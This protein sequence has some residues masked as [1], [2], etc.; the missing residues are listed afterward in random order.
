[1]FY[2][3]CIIVIFKSVGHF[4][5]R[6]KKLFSFAKAEYLLWG[7]KKL[8]SFAKAEYLLWGPKKLFSFAKAEYLLW[9]PKKISG[10][11]RLSQ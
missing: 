9:G 4:R 10:M 5:V 11:K 7:P 1:M 2:L 8:F 6:E 3:F